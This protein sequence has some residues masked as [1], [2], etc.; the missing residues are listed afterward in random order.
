[1]SDAITMTPHIG[2]L[3]TITPAGPLGMIMLRAK[4]GTEGLGDAVK[5]ITGADLP[6]RRMMTRSADDGAGCAV[7][8]MSPDEYL[9]IMPHDAVPAALDRIARALASHHHLAADVSDARAVFHI[10]GPGA[11]E[12]VMTLCPVDL[13]SLPM[14][15]LRRS[16]AAQVAAALWREEDGITLVTFR[17]VARYTYDLLTNA[18]RG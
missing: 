2:T 14:G 5:S 6:D 18:A 15:E 9:L 11:D 10:T 1:M 8:W 16:R 7:G 13:A 17:S 12:V 3:A 4:D